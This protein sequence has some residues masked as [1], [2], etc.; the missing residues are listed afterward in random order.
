[1]KSSNAVVQI[2]HLCGS[3][4]TYQCFV[5]LISPLLQPPSTIR[6][7]RY[8]DSYW[9]SSVRCHLHFPATNLSL[10]QKGVLYSGT[11]IFNHLPA[12]IKS[13]SKDIKQFKYKLKKT[14][15]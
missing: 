12:H 4:G 7:K 6:F 8:W 11:K 2:V 13:L 9:S 5:L 1:M 14:Y 15:F 10:V 3:I